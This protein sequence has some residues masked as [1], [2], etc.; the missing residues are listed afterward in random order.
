MKNM[1]QLMSLSTDMLCIKEDLY[2]E[3][4]KFGEQQTYKNVFRYFDNGKKRMMIIYREEAVQ[5]LV[6]LI[7]NTDYEDRM[8]VYVFSPSED[9]WEG[10][11]EEIQDKVQLCALPQAIYNAYRRILPKK[12]DELIISDDTKTTVQENMPNGMLNFD[13]EEGL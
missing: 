9:P 4:Q 2:T 11:F 7:Q 1:R 10:E 5:Q 12:K 13:E 6:D 3:Q 8:L